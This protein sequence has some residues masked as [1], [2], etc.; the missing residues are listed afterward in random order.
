M[1]LLKRLTALK[2]SNGSSDNYELR[3]VANNENITYHQDGYETS[4]SCSGNA[5]NLHASLEAIYHKFENKCKVDQF[6]QT[7]LK[8]PYVTELKGKQTTLLNK[9]DELEKLEKSKAESEECIENLKHDMINVKR[10]P[11]QYNLEVDKKAS[12]KFWVGLSFLIPLSFYIFI[13]YISTSYSAFFRDY[14]PGASQSSPFGSMFYPQALS[15]AYNESLLELGFI[16]FIPFVFF[17]LGYLIHMFQHK[18]NITNYI[19]MTALFIVNFIFDFLLAFLIDEK[20]YNL[21]KP[22]GGPEFSLEFAVNSPGFWIIIFAG[23]V[24]YIIWGLVFDF[25]MIEH[26][27]RDKIFS[28]IKDKKEEVFNKEKI[29]NKIKEKIE[30]LE[31]EI[32]QIKIRIAELQNIIDGFILPIRNYKQLSTEYLQGWLKY[33]SA[34]IITEKKEKDALLIECKTVH[35]KHII[36][37][38]LNT[39]DYQNKVYTK[40]L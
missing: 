11:E 37:L 21:T 2:S 38:E 36:A 9:K 7:K 4:K 3:I 40:T 13:F 16:I 15:D 10:H 32:G 25:V 27:E 14:T 17:S 6:D 30:K 31:V 33:I 22:L 39:D 35:E 24:S 8:Q 19:K 12:A 28:F 20:I 1:G 34:H 18:K 26:A 5:Y 29:L 23:F